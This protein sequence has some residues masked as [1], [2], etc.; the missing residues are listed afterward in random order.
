MKSETIYINQ[1]TECRFTSSLDDVPSETFTS[2]FRQ[3][4]SAER[5]MG[6]HEGWA[7]VA[8]PAKSI[9]GVVTNNPDQLIQVWIEC[10]NFP[11]PLDK[12]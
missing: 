3:D 7:A 1:G 9:E 11:E 6:S 8:V 2:V 5:T 10:K 12:R 4:C